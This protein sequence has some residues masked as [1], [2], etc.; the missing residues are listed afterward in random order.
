[1]GN[2]YEYIGLSGKFLSFYEEIIDAQCFLFY[3]I[4]SNYGPFC[5]VEINTATFHKLGFAFV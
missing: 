5:S 4:L 3:T 2:L 1:M